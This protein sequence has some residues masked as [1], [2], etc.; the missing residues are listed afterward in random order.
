M[1]ADSTVTNSRFPVDFH[2]ESLA[3]T[4]ITIEL[5]V[6]VVDSP[7]DMECSLGM[8]AFSDSKIDQRFV[9]AAIV[10]NCDAIVKTG[11]LS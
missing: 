1:D 2:V 3:S 11:S 8:S 9:A 4:R 10:I 6:T 5:A 7:G